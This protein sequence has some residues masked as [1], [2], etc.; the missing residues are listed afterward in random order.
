[1]IALP[2]YNRLFSGSLLL[3]ICFWAKPSSFAE[4]EEAQAAKKTVT[5]A[6]RVQPH[7]SGQEG[8]YS[9]GDITFSELDRSIRFPVQYNAI[10][11]PLEYALVGKRG[12]LHETLLSC[13]VRPF[14]LQIVMLLLGYESYRGELFSGFVRDNSDPRSDV[15]QSLEKAPVQVPEVQNYL[16]SVELLETEAVSGKEESF[17]IT[18]WIR[19]GGDL[20]SAQSVENAPWQFTGLQS[21]PNNRYRPQDE[22]S[23]A[24]LYLDPFALL[25]FTGEGNRSD[26]TWLSAADAGKLA[27]GSESS[28]E[29]VIRPWKSE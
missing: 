14:D 16:L 29:I 7:S 8:L 25:N 22:S 17:P 28:L 20:D 18:Q 4:V 23:L 1:M 3:L 12:K 19:S 26:E 13:E 27:Q 2:N 10:E 15:Q 11:K 21:L 5:E 9:Y 24:A 6:L